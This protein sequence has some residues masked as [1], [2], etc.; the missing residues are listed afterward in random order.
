MAKTYGMISK[1]PITSET[2]RRHIT[3]IQE[4]CGVRKIGR[5]LYREHSVLE[6]RDSYHLKNLSDAEVIE[7][8]IYCLGFPNI[9]HMGRPGQTYGHGY[10]IGNC[11][12]TIGAKQGERY[13]LEIINLNDSERQATLKKLEE[14]LK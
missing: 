13:K 5:F 6:D 3:V 8:T 12:V 7:Q 4:K 2:E 10:Q 9:F 1:E 11:A 14:V